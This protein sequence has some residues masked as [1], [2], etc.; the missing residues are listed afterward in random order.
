MITA[1]V[2]KKTY[3]T[4]KDGKKH[5]HSTG[6]SGCGSI[7]QNY[8]GWRKLFGEPFTGKDTDEYKTD[9]EWIVR[10]EEKN[11]R[12]IVTIYNWKD[13][14]NYCG[15]TGKDVEDIT[16]WHIGAAMDAGKHM[17]EDY[18]TQEQKYPGMNMDYADL[19]KSEEPGWSF[20]KSN[21]RLTKLDL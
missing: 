13:G 3:R 10:L 21:K 8:H 11:I 14:K 12:H 1:K 4:D 7:Y 2:F 16:D 18:L 20:W 19:E 6:T 9:A 5:Y 17:L 15:D